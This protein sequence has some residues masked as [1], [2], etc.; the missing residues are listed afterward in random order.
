MSR[1]DSPSTLRRRET[2]LVSV[3][4]AV[5]DVSSLAQLLEQPLARHDAVGVQQQDGEQRALARSA[6]R[7]RP[8]V[9][10]YLERPQDEEFHRSASISESSPAAGDRAVTR[11]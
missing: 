3:W 5:S 9:R 6:D 4:L 1:R 7:E 10:S 8:A 2:W 11:L